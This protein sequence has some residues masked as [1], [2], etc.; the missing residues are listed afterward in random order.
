MPTITINGRRCGFTPGQT[1]LQ[2][3]NAHQIEIPQYCYH[4]GLS[5]VA[6]CRICLVECQAPNPRTG[7]LEPFM[8]GKLIPSCQQ[9]AVDGMV[10][11]S[12]SPKAVANQKAV[13]EYLLINH[14]LDCPVCDQSGECFLQDYSYLYGRGAS[15]FEEQ[16]VKQPKKDVGPNVLL[17]AD[18][19]IM[20]TRCVRFTREVTGTGELMVQ[21]RGNKE[22]IDVFPGVP[23]ANE[24]S[25]NVI[26]LCPVG[27]LLDKDF[28]FAQRV[29]F[30]KQSASI[31]GLTAGGDNLWVHHNQGRVHRI[32]PRPNPAIN[33]WWITDEVRYGWKFVHSPDRLVAAG[34]R[35]FG[36]PVAC[37]YARAYQDALDGIRAAVNAGK[38]LAV[39]VSPMLS[40][41]D[42]F[43][44]GSLARRLDPNAILGVGFVPVLGRDKVYPLGAKE[45]DPRAF[46]VHAEK[47]PNARGVRRV[48]ASLG[49]RI[50]DYDGFLRALG[51]GTGTSDA[52][53]VVLTANY[54]SDWVTQDLQAA[55]GGKFVV[56][57]DTLRTALCDRAD[58]VLPG[59]TWLEKSGTFENAGGVLQAFDRAIPPI[60]G[61]KPEGQH[62]LDLAWVLEGGPAPDEGTRTLVL[63]TTRG[64]VAA[65]IEVAAPFAPEM[66][67]S[68][69]RR[70]LAGRGLSEF[71][72]RVSL[73]PPQA[74]AESD[75]AT[76]EL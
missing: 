19:C 30:L 38:R 24:L 27:A 9:T 2:V 55:L 10:V 50:E 3:A 62:A 48:L 12:E 32:K 46:K 13:M 51:K 54:P 17:Y 44:L 33:K 20:C 22:E 42:A 39:L 64:Q 36:V 6:S 37:D 61:A 16:K 66:D 74:P 7:N 34:R 26:D 43:L 14:P 8:G 11:F 45:D 71:T 29:W 65:G 41:E 76:V 56:L 28:L 75:M 5:I 73:P 15:R 18:R 70:D 72:S 53:A 49:G 60:D 1:I 52:G 69:V 67:A 21:G 40:C 23:L 4:D 35:Q 47:A 59:A 31:D 25:A 58:I 57:I 63:E 68:A